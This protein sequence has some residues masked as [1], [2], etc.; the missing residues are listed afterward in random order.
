MDLLY[1]ISD[2]VGVLGG[3]EA[4]PESFW[5]ACCEV[6]TVKYPDEP[7]TERLDWDGRIRAGKGVSEGAGDYG[8]VTGSVRDYGSHQRRRRKNHPTPQQRQ[9]E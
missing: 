2:I 3:K 9:S 5:N 6:G 7:G 4:M 1:Y 8:D